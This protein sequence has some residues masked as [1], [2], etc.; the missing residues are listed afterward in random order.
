MLT[1]GRRE[2]RLYLSSS[3]PLAIPGPTPPFPIRRRPESFRWR[4]CQRGRILLQGRFIKKE[5]S[6]GERHGV[7]LMISASTGGLRADPLSSPRPLGGEGL[8]VRG[9]NPAGIRVP[10]TPTPLP[11]GGEGLSE[12]TLTPSL[13]FL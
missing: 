7:S 12:P 3:S 6:A 10:L 5:Q 8:G 13:A 9:Q 11:Q 1:G 2:H 4:Q